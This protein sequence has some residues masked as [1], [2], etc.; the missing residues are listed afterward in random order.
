[1]NDFV[2]IDSILTYLIKS[3]DN[4]LM[5]QACE[6]VIKRLMEEDQNV[7]AQELYVK[8]TQLVPRFKIKDIDQNMSWAKASKPNIHVDSGSEVSMQINRFKVKLY[9]YEKLTK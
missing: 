7:I 4:V 6:S 9:D 5:N 1:M 3:N 8:Y 2:N